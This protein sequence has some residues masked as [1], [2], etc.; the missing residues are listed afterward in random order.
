MHYVSGYVN[1]LST[2]WVFRALTMGGAS[3]CAGCALTH[4]KFFEN[5]RIIR[6]LLARHAK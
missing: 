1:L 3:G 2:W 4:L 6:Q 5:A